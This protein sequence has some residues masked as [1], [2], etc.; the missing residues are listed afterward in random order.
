MLRGRHPEFA[1][2]TCTHTHMPSTHHTPQ[3]TPHTPPVPHT[4]QHHTHH[5]PHTC[6]THIP[7]HTI[8]TPQTTHIHHTHAPYTH[9]IHPPH[10]THTHHTL[11]THAIHMPQTTHML[12]I[13][14]T[15][16]PSTP[17]TYYTSHT[18][19]TH[20]PSTHTIHTP[21]CCITSIQSRAWQ[22]AD[23]EYVCLDGRT[24]CG[25]ELEPGMSETDDWEC[26]V[27]GRCW[28]EPT[29][30]SQAS[31]CTC[32]GPLCSLSCHTIHAITR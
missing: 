27:P 23:A 26:A 22:D 16:I 20:M 10:T 11:H 14:H 15:H 12:S 24:G 3:A 1:H 9:A 32:R 28:H 5:T 21:H 30:A 7:K 6:L 31:T 2:T 8:H 4:P 13:T 25:E 17:S 19:T 18:F 29:T